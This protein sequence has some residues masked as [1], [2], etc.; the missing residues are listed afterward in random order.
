MFKKLLVANRGEIAIRIIRSAQELG[1]KTVAIYEETDKAAMHI[2]RADE[3]VCI[4]SGPRKDYLSIERIIQAAKTTGA[5]AIHPGYGFLAENPNFSKQCTEAGL[6]F[7][8]PPPQVIIDMGSKVIARKIMQDAGIPVIPGTPV[9]DLGEAGEKQ[10][11]RF[12]EE[13][14]FPIMVKAVAGGGGRGIRLSKDKDELLKN[15]KVA[16]SEA[17]MAFGNDEIYLEKS[18][19]NPR[20]VEVQILADDHG[21]VIHLGTRNCSIQR[22]HQKM[23]EIA[24]ADLP[25]PLLD[26][27]CETAVRAGEACYYLNA[28]TVEFL[29]DEEDRFYFLEVNTRIQVEHSV[30]EVVTGVDI[31]REQIRIASGEPLSLA[32]EDVTFRGVAIELRINAEDPKSNFMASPGVVQIYMS[33]GGHGIRLDGAVY[34]GYEIPRYYDSMLV[35]LTVYGF[36]WSE[37]VDRL[38]RSLSGFAIAGVKTTI[39]YYKQI[40]KDPDFISQ[41]FDTSY[42]ET[43]PHL[44]DYQEE[45]PEMEKLASLVAEINAHGYNPYAES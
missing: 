20:H 34:Q 28:G 9:L 6:A 23:I 16:R 26:R 32:Q 2:M 30:T 18:L 33:P 37:A 43:H 4:G 29:L 31:V 11:V 25:R 15:L 8:G 12:A 42:I 22:R 44:L 41:N 45:V 19:I 13:H 24:P 35:K 3:A 36:T 39:P 17:K 10:A 14:G 1:I 27:I 7:I 5:E 40:V 38:H 21:T